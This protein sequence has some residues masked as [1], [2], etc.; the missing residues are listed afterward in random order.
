MG[1][2]PEKSIQNEA[3]TAPSTQIVISERTRP[4]G[5]VQAMQKL[6]VKGPSAFSV[7]TRPNQIAFFTIAGILVNLFLRYLLN[8]PRIVW[9]VP[10]IVVLIIG[11][12]PFLVPL[13]EKLLRENLDRIT[14]LESRSSPR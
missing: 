3:K 12:V 7:W 8:S 9:Q 14:S 5:A 13:T 11:G 6:Q 1:V 10:L 2:I 4:L